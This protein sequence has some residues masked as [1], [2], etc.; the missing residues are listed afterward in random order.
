MDVVCCPPRTRERLKIYAG[1]K[2]RSSR[3]W[4]I[5][6]ADERLSILFRRFLELARRSVRFRPASPEEP[7]AHE[8]GN[9]QRDAY[10]SATE[11]TDSND[12]SED[13]RAGR[14][15]NEKCRDERDGGA[16]CASSSHLASEVLRPHG[17]DVSL[18]TAIGSTFHETRPVNSF[19]MLDEPLSKTLS[20]AV[21]A[22]GRRETG[23][24]AHG[25]AWGI[26][27]CLA[28]LP[29]L[30]TGALIFNWGID[31]PYHD[32]WEL[33]PI[34]EKALQGRLSLGDLYAQ[35]NEHRQFFPNLIFVV[36]GLLTRW[37][38]RWEM[39][40]I[41]ALACLISLGIYF[42]GERT[43]DSTRA[44][45]AW[46]YLLSN[47]L[48]F[49]PAQYE[50]WLFGVQ[51]VYLI[52][53]ICVLFC[54][55]VA[56][57]SWPLSVKFTLCMAASAVSSFSCANGFAC[58][59]IA[60]LL[61]SNCR[62]KDPQSKLLWI[63][64]WMAGFAAS[65]ALYFYDYHSLPYPRANA[66]P[67]PLAASG[68]FLILL[69][70][71][72]SCGRPWLGLIAGAVTLSVFAAVCYRLWRMR[73]EGD[74]VARAICWIA[75]GTY[76]I[77]TAALITFGRFSFGLEQAMASRYMGF[78]IYLC[79]ATFYLILMI[80]R[81]T[82]RSEPHPAV[83]WM[84]P[85]SA[86]LALYLGVFFAGAIHHM[87][88]WSREQLQAKACLL[89][90][91]LLPNG[92]PKRTL[93]PNREK[94]RTR[95]DALDAIG[96]LR[97]RLMRSLRV[98]D[99]AASDANVRG[100][101]DGLVRRGETQY[102]AFGQARLKDRPADAVLLAYEDDS[103]QEIVFALAQTEIVERLRERLLDRRGQRET[104]WHTDF[105][106]DALPPHGRRITAWAFD[107]NTG[108]A[109]LLR[110]AHELDE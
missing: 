51:V 11:K 93:H 108:E 33:V 65:V 41:F 35:Q 68:Y 48:I 1:T 88:N 21:E 86:A 44:Q 20:R 38:V 14:G 94:L 4:L 105:R 22:H 53:T 62:A 80:A 61:L 8:S 24:T 3:R 55:F 52:P 75:L 5:E 42:L 85:A 69:G 54:I 63:G 16:L 18:N 36:M 31:V 70:A 29:P 95:A 28:L 45:R 13:E 58:W 72:L 101:F 37:N 71:P 39:G 34:F 40:L 66:L 78:S 91:D 100:S 27:F 96:F 74:L 102:H 76:S 57:S 110:G 6:R 73:E 17:I 107:A 83:R 46:L 81:H 49:S 56:R 67:L 82:R 98:R 89:F 77:I 87:R 15:E 97:P 60:L 26:L 50:N 30:V 43:L 104:Q 23:T 32:Q 103:G 90:I 59:L 64:A 19:D 25:M 109:F 7:R 79:I 12:Q 99:F 2:A 84:T 92:C 106:L 9:Q 47:L 10:A